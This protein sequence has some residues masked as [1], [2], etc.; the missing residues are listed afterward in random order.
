MVIEKLIIPKNI[1]NKLKTTKLL[2]I[3]VITV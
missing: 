1:M 3:Y 2:A